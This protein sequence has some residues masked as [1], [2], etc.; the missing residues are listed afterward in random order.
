MV[1]Y[2]ELAA[3]KVIVGLTTACIGLELKHFIGVSISVI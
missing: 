3:P 2:V 1:L